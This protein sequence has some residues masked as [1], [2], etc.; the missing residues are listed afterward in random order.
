MIRITYV[1]NAVTILDIHKMMSCKCGNYQF[2]VC[3]SFSFSCSY[4]IIVGRKLTGGWQ[5]EVTQ[6]DHNPRL[7]RRNK[8]SIGHDTNQLHRSNPTNFSVPMVLF[9]W[10]IFCQIVSFANIKPIF[11]VVETNMVSSRKKKQ[12]K[13]RFLKLL[14]ESVYN[15]AIGSNT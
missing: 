14:D 6:K 11:S 4:N 3:L 13:N 5:N 12:Q 7:T 8:I 15:S 2:V 9:C 10:S 1:K